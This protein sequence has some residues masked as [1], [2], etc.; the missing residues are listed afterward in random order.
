[1]AL[2]LVTASRAK[3]RTWLMSDERF[4]GAR[5][6][7]LSSFAQPEGSRRPC[8]VWELVAWRMQSGWGRIQPES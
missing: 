3:L 8:V 1:M 5:G 6:Y 2:K 4:R 7:D